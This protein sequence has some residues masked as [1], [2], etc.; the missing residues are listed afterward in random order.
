MI[1]KI[2]STVLIP[3]LLLQLYSCYSMTGISR[4]EL[5]TQGEQKDIRVTTSKFEIFEFKSF[6]YTI[7][8]DTLYGTGEKIINEH[9]TT[10][11]SGKIA[12][13][14]IEFAEASK[15]DN[16]NTCLVTVGAALIV[17]LAFVVLF[18]KAFNDS[19][20]GCNQKS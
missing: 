17:G 3:L 6:D 15:F 16:G 11:F 13:A 5:V 1:K 14:D 8:S 19:L 18:M 2:V 10:P 7:K 9:T 12:V 4:G 20:N